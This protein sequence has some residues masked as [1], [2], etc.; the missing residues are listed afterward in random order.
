MSNIRK[1]IDET[2]SKKLSEYQKIAL[3]IHNKPEV[4][5]HEFF[6]SETLSDQLIKED[7]K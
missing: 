4:S 3:D 2:V 6:A 5:N 7:L 1:S